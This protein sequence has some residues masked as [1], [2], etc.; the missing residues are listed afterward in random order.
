MQQR[1]IPRIVG[2]REIIIKEDSQEVVE[3]IAKE[4]D[5]ERRKRTAAG[6]SSSSRKQVGRS[7]GPVDRHAQRAQDQKAVDRSVDRSP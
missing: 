3:V 6:N 1:S 7:T 5:D 4:I 2:K